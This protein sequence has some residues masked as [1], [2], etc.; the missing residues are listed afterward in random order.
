MNVSSTPTPHR[1]FVVELIGFADGEHGL[2]TST[3][4][5]TSRRGISYLQDAAARPDLYLVNLDSAAAMDTLRE[6]RPNIFCPAVLIGTESPGLPW[7]CIARPIHWAR[8]FEALDMVMNI[9]AE[10][11]QRRQVQAWDGTAR[12]RRTD[13][14][15]QP[16]PALP[17][18]AVA[19]E[20]VLVVDDSTTVRAFLRARL[21][22][23]RFQVDFAANGE[24]AIAMAL[25]RTYTCIFLD[26]EMPGLDGYEVCRRLKADPRT[27]ATAVVMLNNSTSVLDKAR[28]S[29]A[30]CDAFLAKPVDEDEL[31]ATI[32]RFLP[33][34]RRVAS[35]ILG[36]AAD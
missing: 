9:A 33:S 20:S 29:L 30:G 3:F 17:T 26:I 16:V 8:L 12:R 5:L 32:A 11:R 31:L 7:P 36:A 27:A 14:A 10:R 2:L 18:K 25:Q 21:A 6:R 28:R 24:T 13:R 34:A 15:M 19:R 4:R 23:F 35:A 22:P 1:Q